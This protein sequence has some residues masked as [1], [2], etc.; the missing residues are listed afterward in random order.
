MKGRILTYES[1]GMVDGPGLRFIAFLQGCP[2]RCLYCHN[3]DSW[4]P[5]GG[6]L[7]DSEDV[8]AEAMKYRNWMTGGGGLTLSGGEP[9]MQPE[10]TKAILDRTREKGIHTALDTS[11]FGPLHKT[12]PVLASADLILFDIKTMNEDLHK[13]LTGVDQNQ[14]FPAL[15]Y[16]V[17][18]NKPLWVRHVLVPGL[19]DNESDL[20]AL[21]DK[22]L[23]LPNLKRFD[24]LPFHKMGEEKWEEVNRKY[25]LK[26]TQTPLPEQVAKINSIF[27]EAG[28]PVGK[29]ID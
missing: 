24:L 7:V 13:K 17:E 15:D 3:P 20:I 23:K 28:L 1:L 25:T 2:L 18:I 14:T 29:A 8:V 9:L 12:K 27:T 5:K 4:S 10:F 22:L 6:R 11:G 16:L 26:D 21:R 19:T